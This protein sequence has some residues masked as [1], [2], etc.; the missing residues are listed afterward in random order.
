MV[1]S[2]SIIMVMTVSWIAEPGYSL[3]ESNSGDCDECRDPHNPRLDPGFRDWRQG[4]PGQVLC[5]GDQT[6]EA[7]RAEAD[8]E[9]DGIAAKH[10]YELKKVI[11]MKPL[12]RAGFALIYLPCQ[13]VPLAS[14]PTC[15]L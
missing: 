9:K 13:L 2:D 8:H 15:K 3:R 4:T 11:V 7:R 1:G 12:E 10:K 5:Q 14:V 6:A